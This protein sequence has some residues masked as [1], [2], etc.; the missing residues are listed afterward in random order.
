MAFPS[1][2]EAFFVFSHSFSF[3][4]QNRIQFWPLTFSYCYGLTSIT[5]PNSVTSI[6]YRAF[7]GV[8]LASVTSEIEEP[9]NIRDNTFSKNTFMNATLYVPEGTVDKYRQL[10]TF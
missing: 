4:F 1:F 2:G 6:G 9:F 8:D 7:V 10:Y 3:F 5:I